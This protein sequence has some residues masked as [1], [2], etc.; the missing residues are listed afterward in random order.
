MTTA[1]SNYT[2]TDF[3]FYD[4]GVNFIGVDTVNEKYEVNW[5]IYQETELTE[6]EYLENKK[7]GVYDKGVAIIAGRIW[8]GPNKGKWHNIIDIDNKIGFQEFFTNYDNFKRE[9]LIEDHEDDPYSAHV[10]VVTVDRP[11]KSQ[12]LKNINRE[13]QSAIEVKSGG[14]GICNSYPSN[15]SENVNGDLKISPWKFNELKLPSVAPVEDVERFLDKIYSKYNIDYL[16]NRNNK[17]RIKELLKEKN[18][19]PEGTRHNTL[20]AECN[21]IWWENIAAYREGKITADEVF[22]KFLKIAEN[23]KPPHDQADIEQIFLDSEKHVSADAD[24]NP[25]KYLKAKKEFEQKERKEAKQES[26]NKQAKKEDAEY[27]KIDTLSKTI[28]SFEKWQKGMQIRYETIRKTV[29]ELMPDVWP[30]LEFE[31]AVRNILYIR[32]TERPFGGILLGRPSSSK[33]LGIGLFKGQRNIY[34]TDDFTAKSWQSHSTAITKEELKDIDMLPMIENKFFLTPELAPIFN[35]N[36]DELRKSM[37]VLTRVLDGEGYSSNSGAHGQRTFD[38]EMVFVWIG[39][40]A[41]ISPKVYEVMSQLGPRL[42]FLRLPETT[43]GLEAYG[44]M[45]KNNTHRQDK[46]K[47]RKLL[48]EYQDW[49]EACPIA[50]KDEFYNSKLRKIPWDVEKDSEETIRIIARLAELLAPLRGTIQSWSVN[51]V[52]KRSYF[53][54]GL[55]N[56]EDPLRAFF[57]LIALARG[58]ALVKGRNYITNKEIRLI[59]KVVLSTAPEERASVF[60]LLLAHKGQLTAQIIQDSINVDKN[61]AYKTMNELDGLGLCTNVK[62]EDPYGGRPKYFLILKEEFHWFL[63][64][65]FQDLRNEKPEEFLIEES[66]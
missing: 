35:T 55:K 65:D 28:G 30:S 41:I 42:Y 62:E 37:G 1:A 16:K 43:R 44:K 21:R 31:L 24:L 9:N 45:L 23:C 38:K 3:L 39:A 10:H 4:L 59:I 5:G 60:D 27:E 13:T 15:H 64:K 50:V 6:Q 26:D 33:T 54:H 32:E 49:L 22:Q 12:A 58:F 29:I 34:Y 63:S 7:N 19:I 36:E 48:L 20:L 47:I 25:A 53:N 40:T 57:Q 17:E 2:K 18:E 11:I 56:V 46:I 8:R 66:S 14:T 52:D 51:K 61:T